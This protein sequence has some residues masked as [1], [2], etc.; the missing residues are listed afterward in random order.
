MA[1]DAGDNLTLQ[2]TGPDGQLE[3]LK[4]LSVTES[5]E[6]LG[7]WMSPSGNKMKL[8]QVLKQA[9]VDWAAKVKLGRPSKAS[10]W[11]ALTTNISAKLKFPLA[12]CTLTE[13]EC[14]SIMYPAVRAALGKLG[15]ASNLK[16]EFQDGPILDGGAG[17]TSLFHYQGT[18]RI[19]LLIEHC[20]KDTP[21]G[22]QIR[23]CI[24]DLVLEAGLFDQ[25][26]RCHFPRY[27]N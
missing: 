4:Y 2:A 23:I 27:V 10:A 18:S 11:T 20:A 9:A 24:E 26:G 3:D 14:K 7:V 6:M 22:K 1:T 17:A 12:C 16:A 21:T 25:Y 15:I 8:I 19:A 13:K 5:A